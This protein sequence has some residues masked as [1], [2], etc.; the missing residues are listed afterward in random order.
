MVT[1]IIIV[2]WLAFWREQCLQGHTGSAEALPEQ[3]R[4]TV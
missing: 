1:E 3:Y 2:R 4:H